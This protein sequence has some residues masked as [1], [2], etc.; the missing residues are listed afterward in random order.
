MEVEELTNQGTSLEQ[1][2]SH[3]KDQSLTMIGQ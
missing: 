2:I 3:L 1:D